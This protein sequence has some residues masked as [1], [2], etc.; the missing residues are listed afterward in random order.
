MRTAAACR[1]ACS[2]QRAR[3]RV[4]PRSAH[5]HDDGFTLVEVLVSLAVIGT[6]MTALAPFLIRSLAVVAD[7]RNREVAVQLAGDAIERARALTGTTALAGRSEAATNAQWITAPAAVRPYLRT[8]SPAWD[9]SKQIDPSAGVDAGLPTSAVEVPVNGLSYSQNWYLGTCRQQFGSGGPC[10]DPAGPDPEPARPDVPF[11]RVVATVTWPDGSCP[12]RSC[13]YVTTTLISAAPDPVFNLDRPAPKVDDPGPQTGYAKIATPGLQL[14]STGGTLPLVWTVTG[15]PPGLTAAESGMITGTPDDPGANVVYTVTA[16]VKDRRGRTDSAS[17]PWTV[18]A[19]PV[20]MSPGDQST[21]TGS[22]TWL[23]M[24]LTHAVD[25]VAWTA[26][27]LPAGLSIDQA[28]VISGTPTATSRTVSR[29]TVTATDKPG[30]SSQ[31]SFNWT[32]VTLAVPAMATR[33]DRIR[34]SVNFSAPAPTGGVGPYTYRIE[35]VPGE[36]RDISIDPATG[37]ISGRVAY[38]N[39]FFTT[40]YVKDA[41][42]DEVS[43]TFLW[44]VGASQPNDLVITAP[45]PAT[46]DQTGTVGRAVSLNTDLTGGSSSDVTWSAVGLP[47][48]LS[49]RAR[50]SQGGVITGT[51]TTAGTFR[52][53]LKVV[54]STNKYALVVFDWTVLP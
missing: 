7:Q 37:V 25:P 52:V 54:D 29:V 32:V 46:P 1:A 51:P 12:D 40:V 21:H 50:G 35:G 18:W 20:L 15:L 13:T 47:P 3:R 33:T 23:A 16:T 22:P 53:T 43:T 14:T 45:D 39:R 44:N 36:A 38:A 8:M 4:G 10:D 2:P 34:D 19:A 49:I 24:G 48:G 27:G 9:T 31:V 5:G 41:N 11:L 28:G 6:V 26:T 17:F 30:R 42:G